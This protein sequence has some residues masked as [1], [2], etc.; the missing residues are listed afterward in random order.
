MAALFGQG[1]NSN[2]N[3]LCGQ[4]RTSTKATEFMGSRPS[5]TLAESIFAA[6]FQGFAFGNT[7]TAGAAA[8]G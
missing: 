6:V 1:L 8:E 7:G 2:M 4:Q 5:T 3:P